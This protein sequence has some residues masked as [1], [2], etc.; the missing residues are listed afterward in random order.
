MSLVKQI[1]NRWYKQLSSNGNPVLI[2]WDPMSEVKDYNRSFLA[3]PYKDTR[4]VSRE[5]LMNATFFSE[6]NRRFVQKARKSKL[7]NLA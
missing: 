6:K 4:R 5:H 2:E 3:V 7:W 1:N